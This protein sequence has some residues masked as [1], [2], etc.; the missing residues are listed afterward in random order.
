MNLH[1]TKGGGKLNLTVERHYET[2]IT[3]LKKI[4]L[5]NEIESVIELSELTRIN[6]NTLGAILSGKIQ[7]SSSV[8][9]RLISMLGIDSSIAGEIFFKE[10]LTQ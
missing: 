2:D 3:R 5:D 7:P 10:K 1:N 4:M 6:R 9:K 8:M